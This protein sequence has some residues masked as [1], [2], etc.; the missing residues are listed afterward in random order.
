MADLETSSISALP[1]FIK[2]LFNSFM[3]IYMNIIKNNNIV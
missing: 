1:V 2:K 3:Q